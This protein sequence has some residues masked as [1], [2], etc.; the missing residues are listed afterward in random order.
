M[1]IHFPAALYLPKDAFDT[2]ANQVIGCRIAGRL[3]TRAFAEQLQAGEMLTLFSPGEGAAEAVNS[4]LAGQVSPAGTVRVGGQ[5]DPAVLADIGALHLPDPLLAAWTRLRHGGPANAFSITGVIHTVCSEGVL[6]GLAEIPLAPLY[7]WDAVI[8]TST[9]GR[10]VLK[11]VLE[12]RLEAMAA[13]LGTPAASVESLGLPQL[14]VI[15][16]VASDQQPY[17][18]HLSRDGRRQVARQHLGIDTQAFVVTFVGRLSFHS[19]CHPLSL[20][21]AL[22]ALAQ[23]NPNHSIALVECGHIYNP[24][25]AAAYEELRAQF[26]RL[27]FRLVGGLQ[28]ASDLDKW[29]ALAAADVFASPSDNIQETFGLSLLEAMA[30]ELPL[31]VSDW[32]G[33]RD[34]VTPGLNGFLVPTSDVLADFDQADE[35]EVAYRD[36]SISY[37]WMIGLRSLGVI[38]DHQAFVQAFRQLFKEPTLRIRMAQASRRELQQ[39]FSAPAVTQAYRHLWGELA[40]HR[41]AALGQQ[42]MTLPPLAPCYGRLFRHYSTCGFR[43]SGASA[44][45]VP[46]SIS[47]LTST[48]NKSLLKSLAADRWSEFLA[49]FEAGRP[50]DSREL[51]N[52]GLTATQA[53]CLLAAL[54]KL[55]LA[56]V[57]SS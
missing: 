15:P 46:Q 26:P 53:S 4:L 29:Q 40:E 52:I 28:P 43:E 11:N 16:L 57:P 39:R 9:A 22:E 21:R 24:S 36:G 37:D 27:Q 35:I 25:I 32:N 45:A 49:L 47:V 44:I 30:A 54:H 51:K 14:P 12:Q 20:Y 6:Q 41:R 10:T 42:S 7:P 19:K 50:I 38:V 23:E 2:T 31:V 5:P 1:A 17:Y 3:L 34:L 8:C 13:R 33:Y 55:G 56:N 18:P 48:M